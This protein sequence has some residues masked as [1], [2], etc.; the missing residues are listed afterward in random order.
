[1]EIFRNQ[2]IKKSSGLSYR[3][4]NP[5]DDDFHATLI[6]ESFMRGSWRG[7]SRVMQLMIIGVGHEHFEL[8]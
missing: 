1:M 4:K 2:L 7:C 8:I 3:R 5:F 6:E